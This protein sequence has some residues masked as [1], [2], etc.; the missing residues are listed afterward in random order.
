MCKSLEYSAVSSPSETVVRTYCIWENRAR[1]QGRRLGNIKKYQELWDSGKTRAPI[2]DRH[3]DFRFVIWS[4]WR[5]YSGG[6]LNLNFCHT[7]LKPSY[8][9]FLGKR[10]MRASRIMYSLW[11][12]ATELEGRE[13]WWDWQKQHRVAFGTL[14][15]D[16]GW[17]VYTRADVLWW[18]WII[19]F[20]L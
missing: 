10:Y 3:P 12:K 18:K 7:G 8:E 14:Y 11:Q 6:Q 17:I 13:G 20:N 19:V 1:A 4:G 15:Q 2:G 16:F 9:D 5:T